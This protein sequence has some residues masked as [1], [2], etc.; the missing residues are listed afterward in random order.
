MEFMF[1][2][3]TPLAGSLPPSFYFMTRGLHR[4]ESIMHSAMTMHSMVCA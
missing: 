1:I 2:E 4:H 3:G